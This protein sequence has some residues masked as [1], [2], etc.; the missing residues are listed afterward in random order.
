MTRGK[1]SVLALVLAGWLVVAWAA[2]AAAAGV[3]RVRSAS[4][5]DSTR[6]VI[7]LSSSVDFT[8][9]TLRP[10]S[11]GRWPFRVYVDLEGVSNGNAIDT[12][13]VAAD[14]RVSRIRAAQFSNDTARVVIDLKMPVKV[15]VGSLRSAAGSPARVYIDLQAEPG[16]GSPAPAVQASVAAATPAPLV[17][18]PP[19]L[20]ANKRK[21]HIVLDPGHGGRDPGALGNFGMREKEV[22]LD[23]SRRVR[24]LLVRNGV[25]E[26]T[27]TRNDDR[28]VSLEGRKDFANGRKADLFVSIHANSSTTTG[29]HGVETYTLDNSNNRAILRLAKAENG[30]GQLIKDDVSGADTDLKYIL[31]DLVQTGK[32]AE[33]VVLAGA[34]QSSVLRNLGRHYGTIHSL[35]VKKGPFLVLDGVFMPCALIEVGFLS[36]KTEGPRLGA[37]VY[38]QM[39]AEGIYDGLREYLSD[40]R[41]ASLR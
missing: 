29:L 13:R 12:S 19:K 39:L 41:V 32:E 25:A 4:T 11:K 36:H 14:V 6:V 10:D 9:A 21:V 5:A 33:S 22:T 24:D 37:A 8:Y 38:R 3:E 2:P 7:D 15:T 40:E 27:L 18:N 16:A 17:S 26:V 1:G 30:V 20:V 34:L 28:F 31:S 35:G 23:I